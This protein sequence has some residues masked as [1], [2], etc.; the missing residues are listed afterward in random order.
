MGH[1]ASD[2]PSNPTR[3]ALQEII[4]DLISVLDFF[5]V[6]RPVWIGYSMGGRV[7]LAAAIER[8]ARVGSMVLESASP[9]L[10]SEAERVARRSSDA[11][12]AERIV[13]GRIEDFVA[14][15]SELPL[16]DSQQRLPG[17]TREAMREHRLRSSPEGLA[18]CLTGLGPGSQPSYWDRLHEIRGRTLL[19]SGEED[20]KFTS[21][22][23]RMEQLM[24]GASI[25]VVAK[26]GHNVH[27]ERPNEWLQAVGQHLYPFANASKE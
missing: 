16:F 1:G 7:A 8:P 26:A 18:G 5:D 9:G 21:I 15:W 3:Y 10:E 12:L 22:A 20:P 19:I 23:S 25:C 4:E 24:P 6:E 13:R 17:K 14:Y 27:L 11:A 2:A